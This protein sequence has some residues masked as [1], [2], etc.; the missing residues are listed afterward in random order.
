M[1]WIVE[2]GDEFK[3]EFFALKEEVGCAI[4]QDDRHL[5][6]FAQSGFF[7]AARVGLEIGNSIVGGRERTV[8]ATVL[9]VLQP[10]R[11][12]AVDHPALC[13]RVFVV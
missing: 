10:F 6:R 11:D 7:A 4:R 2:I 1:S 12:A 5:R 9:D 8:Y 3:P 13:G